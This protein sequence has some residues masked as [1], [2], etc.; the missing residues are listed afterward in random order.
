M[1]ELD[2][3]EMRPQNLK[4]NQRENFGNK[5]KMFAYQKFL[6]FGN[7]MRNATF[8]KKPKQENM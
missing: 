3:K 8:G 1:S 5:I 4:E 7:P 2:Q 6:E